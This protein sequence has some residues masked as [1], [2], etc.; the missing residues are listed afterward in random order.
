MR[1]SELLNKMD[2]IYTVPDKKNGVKKMVCHSGLSLSRIHPG[3]S[4]NG[5]FNACIL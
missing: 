4:C 3:R 1:G 2:L 5:C